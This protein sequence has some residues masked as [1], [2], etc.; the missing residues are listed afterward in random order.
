MPSTNSL[1][2]FGRRNRDRTCDLCLV[3][4]ALSQLSYPP[5][6]S[7][8]RQIF[9]CYQL[10]QAVS[11]KNHALFLQDF[12]TLHHSDSPGALHNPRSS[13]ERL[14]ACRSVAR[15]TRGGLFQLCW[16]R[17]GYKFASSRC[18]HARA[19]PA[20]IAKS[21]PPANRCVANECRSMWGDGMRAI[22][23]RWAPA[24]VSNLSSTASAASHK[25][26]ARRS[27]LQ[28]DR[29]NMQQIRLHFHR[30]AARS[31]P[32]AACPLFR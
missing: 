22:P 20:P 5:D 1:Y 15:E 32:H 23:S 10:H 27:V 16:S 30:P 18:R 31:A 24:A 8:S 29:S 4:A 12:L 3:R 6:F 14:S 28:E 17:R 21:A 7:Q 25:H 2:F 26:E 19:S 13:P 11:T 9:G